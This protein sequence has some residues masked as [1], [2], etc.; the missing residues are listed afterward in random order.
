MGALSRGFSKEGGLCKDPAPRYGLPSWG[1][2]DFMKHIEYAGTPPLPSITSPHS[3]RCS[4]R[5]IRKPHG[6]NK[7]AKVTGVKGEMWELT[8]RAERQ[9]CLYRH[10]GGC[11]GLW[12]LIAEL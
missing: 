1:E 3:S 11:W 8:A 5:E 10:L 2:D 6:M 9:D 4:V 12:L 7:A